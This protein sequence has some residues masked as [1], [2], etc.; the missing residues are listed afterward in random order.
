MHGNCDPVPR[1]LCRPP[2]FL[3]APYDAV[4]V[5]GMFSVS[6][7]LSLGELVWLPVVMA[8]LHLCATLICLAEP[9][10][11]ELMH[12]FLMSVGRGRAWRRWR[13]VSLSPARVTGDAA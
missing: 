2:M 9:R 11:F 6:L 12:R 13:G 4:V 5:N 8:P 3:M 1:G 7:C 10:A